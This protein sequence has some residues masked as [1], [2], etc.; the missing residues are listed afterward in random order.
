MRPNPEFP[1]GLV[2]FL[3]GT[4][5]KISLS[6]QCNAFLLTTTS[7]ERRIATF[8]TSFFLSS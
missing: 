3:K 2:I 4:L 6:G 7:F 1:A 8:F 5:I